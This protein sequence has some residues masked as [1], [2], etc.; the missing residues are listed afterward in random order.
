MLHSYFLYFSNSLMKSCFF[1]LVIFG[2]RRLLLL[3]H[4][5]EL[6]CTWLIALLLFGN[7]SIPFAAVKKGDWSS[8]FIF[9]FL[10][11][12][13]LTRELLSHLILCCCC[14][15]SFF[16]VIRKRELPF[17]LSLL[18]PVVGPHCLFVFPK[19]IQG[20]WCFPFLPS[21]FLLVS[22]PK[23]YF[24]RLSYYLLERARLLICEKARFLGFI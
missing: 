6:F 11:V 1:C 3:S 15:A 24:I 19:R 5:S 10:L 7:C 8:F 12:R 22:H 21:F 4:L 23:I 2:W 13:L 16:L 9:G 17:L 14:C 20:F 18:G